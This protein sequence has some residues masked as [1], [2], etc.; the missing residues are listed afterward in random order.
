MFGK[1]KKLLEAV[2]NNDIGGVDKYFMSGRNC[3]DACLEAVKHNAPDALAKLLVKNNG[4]YFTDSWNANQD[5][6]A[7][8]WKAMED[9]GSPDNLFMI[10]YTLNGDNMWSKLEEDRFITKGT[11]LDVL[12]SILEKNPALFETCV[13]QTGLAD[14]AKLKF[15]LTF[16]PKDGSTQQALNAAL[17]SAAEKG[18]TGKVDALL[19]HNAD[20]DYAGGRSLARAAENGHDGTVGLLLPL[21][22][23]RDHGKDIL[24]QLELKG[25]NARLVATIRDAMRAAVQSKPA[26][27]AQAAPQADETQ[28]YLRLDDHTLAD[29]Q[30]LPNG[31]TL[32]TLF[33]FATEQQQI[34][35]T[36]ANN[37]TAAPVVVP[38]SDIDAKLRDKLRKT[39]AA[40][41]AP[42]AQPAANGNDG[43]AVNGNDGLA[44]NGYGGIAA[45]GIAKKLKGTGLT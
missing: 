41:S 36:D 6:G 44:G 34:L 8:L 25:A 13:N 26:A 5:L 42:Q 17:I 37:N 31:A 38:F 12:R 4:Y 11:P 19:Q 32:T 39:F 28:T 30:I 7:G 2:R 1:K 15:I 24:T 20:P 43:I 10:A 33:N 27:A 16:T 35:V 29:V 23:L 9:A 40:L 18:D 14:T 21:V 45:K 3:Y 22:N